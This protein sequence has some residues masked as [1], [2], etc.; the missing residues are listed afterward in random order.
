[1]KRSIV[2]VVAMTFVPLVVWAQDAQKAKPAIDIAQKIQD[3]GTVSKG[4]VI[5]AT[6]EVKNTGTAPLEITQV[7]P[8]CGCTVADF[9]KTVAPGGTGK[10]QAQVNT[11]AFSG[12]ITKAILVF[13][14]DPDNP[15]VN[16]VVKADVRSFVEVLP[17]PL[18]N[19]NVLQGEPATDKVVLTTADGSP[20]KITGVD[21][22]GGPYKV[23]YRELPEKERLPNYKGPQW[24]VTVTVPADAP[25][26]LLTQKITVSTTAAKAPQVPLN[27]TGIVRPIIQVVPGEVNFGVVSS[28]APIGRNVIL[29]NNRQESNL[30]LSEAKVSDSAFKADIVPLTAGQRYQVAVSLI[31]GAAKGE[32]KGTLTITTNDPSRPTIQ[33][34][35][36]ATVQ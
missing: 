22:G 24:E 12:P 32:H 16:L 31:P 30:E 36:E 17:R 26:G 14:N 10:I 23:D 8:T 15:Q 2:A 7:R 19:F 18:L 1:M 4:D 27:V 33:V 9:D 25:Q 3:F 21:T 20:M 5:K 35:V 13:S 29:I 28:T 11:A 34:P 6:F